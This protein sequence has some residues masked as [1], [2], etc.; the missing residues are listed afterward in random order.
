MSD[1]TPTDHSHDD[2]RAD[3]RL[4]TLKFAK[5]I[6]D[7]GKCVY[8]GIL[9]NLSRYG[10]KIETSQP[11]HIPDDFTLH[12]VNAES[13]DMKCRVMWRRQNVIGIKFG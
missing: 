2:Q 7:D 12:I 8:D 10:A 4:T 1:E 13:A 6:F 3:N 11:T 5:L 9:R